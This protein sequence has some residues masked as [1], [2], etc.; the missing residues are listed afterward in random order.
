MRN[1]FLLRISSSN[2]F[3]EDFYFLEINFRKENLLVNQTSVPSLLLPPSSPGLKSAKNQMSF[4]STFHPPPTLSDYPI[5]NTRISQCFSSASSFLVRVELASA[6]KKQI[7]A[8]FALFSFLLVLLNHPPSAFAA[9]KYKFLFVLGCWFLVLYFSSAYFYFSK[10]Q[11]LNKRWK[12]EFRPREEAE[13]LLRCVSA[14]FPRE[15]IK[16]IIYPGPDGCGCDLWMCFGK[17]YIKAD[18][19]RWGE[20]NYYY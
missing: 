8:D 3:I 9:H 13:K 16:V 11:I 15:I 12:I 4:T 18:L 10:S 1:K 17:S 14:L 6:E 20:E 7:R 5:S 2:I 19:R